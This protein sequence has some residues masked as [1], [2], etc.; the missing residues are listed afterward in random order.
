VRKAFDVHL[1]CDG[2]LEVT[3]AGHDDSVA[4]G[5]PWGGPVYVGNVMCGPSWRSEAINKGRRC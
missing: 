5:G 1:V 3:G 4:I 2:T